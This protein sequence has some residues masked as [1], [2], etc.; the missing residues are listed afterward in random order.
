M[1]I[2]RHLRQSAYNIITDARY[3]LPNCAQSWLTVLVYIVFGL[4]ISISIVAFPSDIAGNQLLTYIIT[5][6][7]PF[8]YLIFI[9]K[10]RRFEEVN[11]KKGGVFT[12]YNIKEFKGIPITESNTGK[13]SV[14]TLFFIVT[15]LT[16]T[17]LIAIEPLTAWMSM[18]E[19]YKRLLQSVIDGS[20]GQI[21]A[22]VIAAP[23]L[24]EL[25]LRGFIERGLIYHS[26]GTKAIIISAAIFGVM[27]LNPWQ[28]LPAFIMGLFFGWLYWR[29]HNLWLTILMHLLTNGSSLITIRLLPEYSL[30]G[31]SLK[32]FVRDY[33]G[34]GV[35]PI[36]V[37]VCAVLSA[38][39]I[40]FL[41][42][43]LSCGKELFPTT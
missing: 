16:I 11:A 20:A 12:T 4:L 2:L 33:A 29:T 27:H 31:L 22:I 41:N 1:E 40:Y 5:I 21:I 18:P 10:K 13:L 28:A 23:L 6:I 30:A 15:L 32:D 36:L 8:V 3:S 38:A 24:E 35:Y 26:G 25:L 14:F 34:E 39:L 42:R 7:P 17:L 43:K 37:I 9:G 19:Y